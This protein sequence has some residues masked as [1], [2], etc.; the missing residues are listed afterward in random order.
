MTSGSTEAVLPTPTLPGSP[1]HRLQQLRQGA[2]SHRGASRRRSG[3]IADSRRP[4]TAGLRRSWQLTGL[5]AKTG[6]FKLAE[7]KALPKSD[8]T[9]DAAAGNGQARRAQLRRPAALRHAH[10][11]AAED[12]PQPEE[13][14]AA[15]R[16]SHHRQRRLQDRRSPGA[17]LTRASPRRRSSSPMSATAQPLPEADGFVRLIV[18]GDVAAGRY[19]SN[20]VK[21]EVKDSLPAQTQGIAKPRRASTSPAAVA[22]AGSNRPREAQRAEADEGQPHLRRHNDGLRRRAPERLPPGRRHQDRRQQEERHPHQGHRRR[23]L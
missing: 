11:R 20:V 21:I 5:L 22:K 15:A 4:S 2:R 6:T 9:T 23:W 19:I 7:L 1:A 12:G 10:G 8:V 13:R 3:A 18:P 14:P 17:R 16:R